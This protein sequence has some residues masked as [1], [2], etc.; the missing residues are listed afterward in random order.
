MSRQKYRLKGNR[1]LAHQKSTASLVATTGAHNPKYEPHL[2][3]FWR[4]FFAND[5][6]TMSASDKLEQSFESWKSKRKLKRQGKKAS[7]DRNPVLLNLGLSFASSDEK[8]TMDIG[9]QMSKVQLPSHS[10]SAKFCPPFPFQKVELLF[11]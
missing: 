1:V 11:T 2:Y 8:C 3:M 7:I 4:Q 6:L 10:L 5:F 9:G